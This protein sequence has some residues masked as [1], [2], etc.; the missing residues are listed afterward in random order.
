MTYNEATRHSSQGQDWKS[1][2]IPATA[3][4]LAIRQGTVNTAL[5]Y[6]I[7]YVCHFVFRERRLFG[8]G[9]R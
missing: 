7:R 6:V 3:P 9:E 4:L 5:A 1:Y 2:A 8:D